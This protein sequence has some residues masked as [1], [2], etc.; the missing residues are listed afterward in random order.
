[1]LLEPVKIHT[2]PE[3]TEPEQTQA[4]VLKTNTNFQIWKVNENG[5]KQ[6]QP[7]YIKNSKFSQLY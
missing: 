5:T 6:S 7:I 1:M 4:L 2:K 3:Q